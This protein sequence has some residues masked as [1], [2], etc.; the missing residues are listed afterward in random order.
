M[1]SEVVDDQIHKLDLASAQGLA[2]EETYWQAV[3]EGE[4]E[5]FRACIRE[6]MTERD[7]VLG[8][9]SRHLT[10]DSRVNGRA[11]VREQTHIDD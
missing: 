6:L 8:A 7:L 3:S 5:F 1:L 10:H 2:V 4:R 11:K 9:L